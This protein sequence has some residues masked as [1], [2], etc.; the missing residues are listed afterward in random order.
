MKYKLITEKQEIVF[1]PVTMTI[2]VPFTRHKYKYKISYFENKAPEETGKHHIETFKLLLGLHCNYKCK[3]CNQTPVKEVEPSKLQLDTCFKVL[4]KVKSDYDLR[5][6]FELWGGEP[7]VY[8]KAL[9][10]IIPYIRKL[11]PDL[12]ITMI[13]NGSLLNKEK[14]QFFIEHKVTLIISHDGPAQVITRNDADILGTKNFDEAFSLL[15]P[16]PY[17]GSFHFVISQYNCNLYDTVE[18]FDKNVFEG[19]PLSTE[20]IINRFSYNADF[21]PMFNNEQQGTLIECFNKMAQDESSRLDFVHRFVASFIRKLN[22]GDKYVS[23]Q[24]GCNDPDD[25]TLSVDMMGNLLTCHAIPANIALGLGNV[26]RKPNFKRKAE[27]FIGWARRDNCKN[28]IGLPICHG[29]CGVISNEEHNKYYC[30]NKWLE[31][32]ATISGAMGRLFGERL[33]AV[34][35]YEAV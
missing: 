10:Q 18:W 21:F 4:D 13:T 14:A 3:Y 19:V 16:T 25:T 6:H 5:S 7:L 12:P 28:C 29:G 9:K 8:W 23:Y 34:Q 1:D 32:I 20:G 30:T 24:Y 27:S 26:L 35:P 33:L 2:N 11:W 17:F 15:A 31:G 22:R